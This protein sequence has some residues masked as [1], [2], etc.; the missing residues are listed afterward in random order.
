[1]GINED[2]LGVETLPNSYWPSNNSI[3]VGGFYRHLVDYAIN[4]SDTID[5]SGNM[6]DT[7]II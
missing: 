4:T 5:W 1:M 2:G 6:A 7:F 3:N